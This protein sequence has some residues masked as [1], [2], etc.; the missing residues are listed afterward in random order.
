[1]SRRNRPYDACLEQLDQ[2]RALLTMVA[3]ELVRLD[4]KRA[5][6][7]L[8]EVIETTRRPGMARACAFA[9]GR[10]RSPAGPRAIDRLLHEGKLRAWPAAYALGHLR[11]PP[12]ILV[13]ALRSPSEQ[14]YRWAALWLVDRLRDAGRAE[15][16]HHRPTRS[17]RTLVSDLERFAESQLL[18]DALER[19]LERGEPAVWD[20][21]ARVL[22]AWLSA[23]A[24]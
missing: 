15:V 12:E 24:R 19:V 8:V 14:A 3:A 18:R 21:D 10:T 13:S 20:A 11:L 2:P 23:T 7:D 22:R 1:M 16:L 17:D 4:E 9:L 6:A 5:I